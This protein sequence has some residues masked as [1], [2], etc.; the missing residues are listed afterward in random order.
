MARFFDLRP[1]VSLVWFR[2]GG[3]SEAARK[4]LSIQNREVHI[5]RTMDD[6]LQVV[7]AIQLEYGLFLI[8]GLS[9]EGSGTGNRKLKDQPRS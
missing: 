6:W 8:F 5:E 3:L 1:L 9:E 7:Y 4:I 2:F